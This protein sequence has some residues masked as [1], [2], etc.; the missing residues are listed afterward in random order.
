MKLP[1]LISAVESHQPSARNLVSLL[2]ADCIGLSLP[3]RGSAGE[4]GPSGEECPPAR[5][6]RSELCSTE[7][8]DHHLQNEAVEI[9]LVAY[10]LGNK[11]IKGGS[12]HSG[13]PY[14]RYPRSHSSI[15]RAVRM[16]RS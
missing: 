13:R 8:H 10:A 15:L 2:Q 6:R 4:E 7:D 1:I 14:K 5:S 12:S 9:V 3:E 16:R 11:Q